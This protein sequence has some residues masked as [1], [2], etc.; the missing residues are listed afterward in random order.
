MGQSGGGRRAVDFFFFEGGFAV[1]LPAIT[2]T[3]P[4]IRA[5]PHHVLSALFAPLH[6]LQ[7]VEH[8]D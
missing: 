6:P 4:L 7:L 8:S 3:H 5:L 1:A 2:L